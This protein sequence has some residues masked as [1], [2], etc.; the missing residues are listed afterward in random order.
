VDETMI[1][2][3][4]PEGATRAYA[5]AIS[6]AGVVVG[7]VVASK[8][9]YSDDHAAVWFPPYDAEPLLLPRWENHPVQIAM[10]ITSAGVISGLVRTTTDALVQWQ[11]DENGAVLSGPTKLADGFLLR[12]A[13]RDLD[14]VGHF[15]FE[16]ASVFRVDGN[17]R[18]DLGTLDDHAFSAAHAAT[19]REQGRAIQI[20]GYSEA[21]R[22]FSSG[23]R[24]VLWNVDAADMVAGP[25][26]L[27]MP[28][29]LR[30]RKGPPRQFESIA[31][32]AYSINNKSWVVGWSLRGDGRGFATLWQPSQGDE[33][34]DD[35]C[36]PHPRTGVC[37]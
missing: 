16:V 27:G 29:A 1:V 12:N 20:A 32:R 37:R 11:I 22:T 7:R 34:G 18:I 3:S 19:D 6:D 30:E 28:A 17:Y 25:F 36:N 35:D 2:L 8:D 15:Q 5:H 24:A 4:T 31:A 33:G 9:D 13:A 14:L 10:G 21:T 26:D 23:S